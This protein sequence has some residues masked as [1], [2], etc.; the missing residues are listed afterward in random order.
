MVVN[1]HPLKDRA[2]GIAHH[3]Q[4]SGILPRETEHLVDLAQ[5]VCR[6]LGERI[7]GVLDSMVP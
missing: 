3:S 2:L 1:A 7:R 4:Q 6:F 5:H